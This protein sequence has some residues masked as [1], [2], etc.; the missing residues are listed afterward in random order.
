[1]IGLSYMPEI[2]LTFTF[3]TIPSAP[4]KSNCQRQSNFRY[5][6][7]GPLLSN[8]VAL[9]HEDKIHHAN[10]AFLRVPFFR[11]TRDGK[12]SRYERFHHM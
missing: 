10:I 12:T 3:L 5:S 8:W 6:A 4:G 11:G 7:S 1:M 9:L 2:V